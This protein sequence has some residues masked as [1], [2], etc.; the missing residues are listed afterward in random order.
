MYGKAGPAVVDEPHAVELNAVVL[1]WDRA[2]A[3][4]R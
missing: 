3:A 1:R 2:D 4:V